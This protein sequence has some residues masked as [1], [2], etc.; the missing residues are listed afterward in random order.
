MPGYPCRTGLRG[1]WR[2]LQAEHLHRV[3]Q[4]R[5]LILHG[6]GRGRRLFDQGRILLRHLVH[7]TDGFIHLLDAE[8]LLFARIRD[9]ADDGAQALDTS[10]MVAPA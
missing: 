1:R 3:R 10:C 6:I 5:R 7:L 8:A 2:V 9:L 4:L